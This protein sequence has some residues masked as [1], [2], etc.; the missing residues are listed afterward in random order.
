MRTLITGTH[1]EIETQV[2]DRIE[3]LGQ[4]GGFLSGPSQ[5][6][7]PE[8]PVWNKALMYNA[9]YKCGTYGR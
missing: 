8:I 7:L 1:A 9:G 4:G 3:M 2:R 6:C 5:G